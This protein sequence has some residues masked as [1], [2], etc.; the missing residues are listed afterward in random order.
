MQVELFGVVLAPQRFVGARQVEGCACRLRAGGAVGRHPRQG[1]FQLSPGV[2]VAL[3]LVEHVA[4]QHLCLG[5]RLGGLATLGLQQPQRFSGCGQRG[6]E[7]AGARQRFRQ[8]EPR[9][10]VAQVCLAVQR[11]GQPGRFFQQLLCCRQQV[12]FFAQAAQQHQQFQSQ[13]CG[14]LV[15]G[16]EPLRAHFQKLLA[17]DLPGRCAA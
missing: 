8:G 6:F 10:G 17:R 9:C 4:E 11:F 1:G 5:Q 12:E 2:F 15:V 13:I 7:M 14:F 3:L 16:Q